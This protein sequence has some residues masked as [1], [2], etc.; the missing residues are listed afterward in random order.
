LILNA[1]EDFN[2]RL[3]E[4]RSLAEQNAEMSRAMAV[5]RD[6]LQREVQRH[7]H[8]KRNLETAESQVKRLAALRANL[9]REVQQHQQ[10]HRSLETL[11]SQVITMNTKV[12]KTE[13]DHAKTAKELEAEKANVIRFKRFTSTA[14]RDKLLN[15]SERLK[16]DKKNL[17]D[18]KKNLQNDKKK[19]QAKL[20]D[21]EKKLAAPSKK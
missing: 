9:Q 11:Q 3:D 4:E 12:K 6:D 2:K 16:K 8:T 18:D 5:Q 21:L 19:L 7:K 20:T 14:G 10:T 13:A 17:E 15:D 1:R